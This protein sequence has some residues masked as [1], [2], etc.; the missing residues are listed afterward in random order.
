MA[1]SI[2]RARRLRRTQTPA[3]AELWRG[4]RNR[5]LNGWKFC[6]Q[7]PIGRFGV[8]FACVEAKLIAEVDGATHPTDAERVSDAMRTV[9][10]EPLGFARLRIPSAD[11]HDHPDGP[12]GTIR[13]AL[14]RRD[15]V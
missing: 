2:P 9:I 12:R 5:A 15:S 3:E 6:R 8:D 10:L 7:H 11:S 14:E 13:A 1:R 4:L